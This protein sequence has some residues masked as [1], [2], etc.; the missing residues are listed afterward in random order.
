MA[1]HL[2]SGLALAFIFT[3]SV[4]VVRADIAYDLTVDDCSAGGGCLNGND[5]GTVTLSQDG[6]DAVMFTV[7]LNESSGFPIAFQKNTTSTGNNDASFAFNSDVSTLSIS[8]LSSGWI[9]LS[10]DPTGSKEDGF[11]T[12]GYAIACDT[13]CT[14]GQTT[15]PKSVSFVITNT[16]GALSTA[17]FA[18]KSTGGG[19]NA[20]F[21]ADVVGFTG[22][23]GYIG[24]DTPGT[25][26]NPTVPDGGTTAMLLSFALVGM[27][28]IS[29]RMNNRKSS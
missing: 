8:G 18:V 12:F 3:L 1:R 11:G 13:A 9:P 6:A 7:S 15:N 14:T 16:A 29:R 24:G 19:T 28:L 2:W 26:H 4:P 5:G 27:G 20:Y 22:N 10:G 25:E 23:T 21:A 17:D